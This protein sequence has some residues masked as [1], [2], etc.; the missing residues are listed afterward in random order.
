MKINTVAAQTT[1]VTLERMKVRLVRCLR[2]RENNSK[3]SAAKPKSK[4]KRRSACDV[5][6]GTPGP[7][8]DARLV[9]NELETFLLYINKKM[10][11]KIVERANDQMRIVSQKINADEFL[12]CYSDTNEEEM[13][14]W[15]ALFWGLAP[16]Y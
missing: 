10:I 9:K 6:K 13:F 4:L 5:V 8:L 15:T 1:K 2:K 7:R 11:T 14:I 16:Q 12:F 3:L